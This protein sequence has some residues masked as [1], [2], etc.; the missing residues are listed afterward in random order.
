MHTAFAALDCP[1]LRLLQDS[2][3]H[4]DNVRILAVYHPTG[5][6]QIPWSSVTHAARQQRAS[7]DH[8]HILLLLACLLDELLVTSGKARYVIYKLSYLS[9]LPYD[10][11]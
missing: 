2:G 8:V 3:P 1:I 5:M 7:V 11:V 6:V 4:W 9:T 10:C